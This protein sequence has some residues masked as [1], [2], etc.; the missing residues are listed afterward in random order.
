MVELGEL[1]ALISIGCDSQP[2]SGEHVYAYGACT[3][4]TAAL[5]FSHE[6]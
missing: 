4:P 5:L 2:Y 3:T 6:H 1:A